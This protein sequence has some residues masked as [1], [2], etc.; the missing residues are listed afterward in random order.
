[1]SLIAI[2]NHA[3]HYGVRMFV[4]AVDGNIYSHPLATAFR[5]TMHRQ[6]GDVVGSKPFIGHLP[7]AASAKCSDYPECISDFEFFEGHL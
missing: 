3:L 7:D 6:C 1:M 5:S 4:D 2:I